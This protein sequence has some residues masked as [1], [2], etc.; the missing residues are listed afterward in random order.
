[1][2]HMERPAKQRKLQDERED[3]QGLILEIPNQL[4]HCI[5]PVAQLVHTIRT[6]CESGRGDEVEFEARFGQFQSSG[7]G[8][9]TPGVSA[10]TLSTIEKMLE[11]FTEWDSGTNWEDMHDY[12]YTHEGASIRTTVHFQ[13]DSENF[14]M[15]HIT[16]QTVNQVNL[17]RM[18]AS[19]TPTS[20][21]MRVSLNREC[22][23]KDLPPIVTPQFVRIKKR[24]S[25][26]LKH[27]RFDLSRVWEGKTRLEAE[28]RQSKHEPIYEF[29]VEWVNP[30]EYLKMD[31]NHTNEYVATSLLLK[32]M[33]FMQWKGHFKPFES[34]KT[35]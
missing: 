10:Q 14:D 31:S 33:D 17:K 25:F 24:R 1:M 21:D 16:K 2:S 15:T 20:Y 34:S 6:A 29:E 30:H 27:W 5:L 11:S 19:L 4:Q 35:S 26:S 12:F 32:M 18:G 28:M 23:H 3:G 7:K 8:H 9:F 13:H 22:P